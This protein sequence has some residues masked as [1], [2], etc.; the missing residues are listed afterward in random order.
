MVTLKEQI[1]TPLRT[2]VSLGSYLLGLVGSAV[3]W[4]LTILG[5]TLFFQLYGTTLNEQI[6]GGEAL[7]VMACGLLAAGLGM[8]GLKGYMYFSY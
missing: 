8:M 7:L 3:G 2:P 5:L 1:P 4:I 6:S